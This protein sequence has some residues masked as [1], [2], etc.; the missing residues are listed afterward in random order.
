MIISAIGDDGDPYRHALLA[1]E[2]CRGGTI[3][4]DLQNSTE[5]KRCE[6]ERR[7]NLLDRARA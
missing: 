1:M 2:Q 6:S 3:E 4:L 7:G 5:T